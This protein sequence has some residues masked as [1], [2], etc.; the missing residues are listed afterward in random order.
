MKEFSPTY[1]IKSAYNSA[2]MIVAM[3]MMHAKY[4]TEVRGGAMNRE[5]NE[6]VRSGKAVPTR[7]LFTAELKEL[8]RRHNVVFEG[9]I[10]EFVS[11]AWKIADER[12]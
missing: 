9:G 1:L 2:S 12:N 6:L 10:D 8:C 4:G 3:Q 7:E 5:C 11:G